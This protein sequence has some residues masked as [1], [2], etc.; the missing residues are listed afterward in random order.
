MEV[1]KKQNEHIGEII[2]GQYDKAI[3]VKWVNSLEVTVMFS[4][5][6]FKTG[7]YHNFLKS[8]VHPK[9][10]VRNVAYRGN[11]EMLNIHKK[12]EKEWHNMIARCYEQNGE[13]K[14]RENGVQVE[15]C[16]EWLCMANFIQDIRKFK[17]YKEWL[18]CNDN[19][20]GYHLD[21]DM[22][23]F[24]SDKS[25]YMIKRIYS[26][27]TCAFITGET[28]QKFRTWVQDRFYNGQITSVIICE[29]SD[30]ESHA[31]SDDEKTDTQA[32]ENDYQVI[33]AMLDSSDLFQEHKK[34]H[35]EQI[36]TEYNYFK[37]LLN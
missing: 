20:N 28:N 16:Q 21:K 26:P 15:V 14:V 30:V 24:F 17:N 34:Q 31:K 22:G 5:G 2:H 6:T 25:N 32:I 13:V 29:K 35:M 27:T 18:E 8:L 7:Q 11:V 9:K 37:S 4:D 3:I 33:K 1:N 12:E 19:Y 10:T 23:C 36:L